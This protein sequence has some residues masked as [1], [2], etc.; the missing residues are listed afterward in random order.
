VTAGK[1]V[2]VA[3]A[4]LTVSLEVL[5]RRADGYHDIVAEMVTLDLFDRLVVDPDGDGLEI[6]AVPVARAEG[7]TSGPANLI[8]R[9]LD[10]VGRRAAVRV[11]KHIPLGGGLGG[12]SADAAAILRWAG[13]DDVAVAASLGG[14]VPFC[15]VGGRA[16]VEGIG[17]RVTPLPYRLSDYVLLVPPFG[18]DT[19]AVYRRWDELEEG[20][21]PDEGRRNRRNELTRAALDVEPR[22]AAWQEAFA[23]RTGR[24]PVLAGSGST[25]F[26]EGSARDLGLED[27]EVF[28]RLGREEGHLVPVR[29][30][31]AGW[32][33]PGTAAA[34]EN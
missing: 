10:A 23:E 16:R 4:K 15:A 19:A 11:E 7:L 1:A 9:A 24:S 3:P 17:E 20:G 5:G 33:G 13:V 34:G 6:V 21:G 32:A 31:P 27:G 2:L 28:L 8:A 30:V 29:T 14:D 22:L 12:G 26:V 18:V 25:W